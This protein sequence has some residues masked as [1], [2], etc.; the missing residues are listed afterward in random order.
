MIRRARRTQEFISDIADKINFDTKFKHKK[1]DLSHDV[2]KLA[3]YFRKEFGFNFEQQKKIKDD[4]QLFNFLRSKLESVGVLV[5]RHSFP[6][7]DARAFSIVDKSPFI[8]VLNNKDGDD[9]LFSPKI[10]YK[11]AS[12]L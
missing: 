11:S 6:L 2:S 3:G 12:L 8:I 5:L 7:D 4:Q 9:T 1:Y 10:F